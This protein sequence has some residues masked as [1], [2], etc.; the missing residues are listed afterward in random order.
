VKISSSS[1]K[2]IRN[3]RRE[4]RRQERLFHRNTNLVP[5]YTDICR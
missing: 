5:T 1:F 2:K 4:L 3:T